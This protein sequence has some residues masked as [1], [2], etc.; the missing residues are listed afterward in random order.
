MEAWAALSSPL[1]QDF[2]SAHIFWD[3][4]RPINKALL[5][6]LDLAALVEELKFNRPAKVKQQRLF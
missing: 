4:K 5:Q 2:F 6:K 3:A 1:A